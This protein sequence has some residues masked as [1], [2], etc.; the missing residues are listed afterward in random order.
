MTKKNTHKFLHLK[1]SDEFYEKLNNLATE[2]NIS[3]SELGIKIINNYLSSDLINNIFSQ[4]DKLEESTVEYKELSDRLAILESKQ[5]E[6]EKLEDR[7]LIME[8]LMDSIQRQVTV[9]DYAG[10]IPDHL[11]D[12]SHDI[13]DEPDEILSDFLD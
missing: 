12:H 13:D 2:N 5:I 4:E 8:K 3:T 1:L 11:I 9:R 10:K 6:I 7:F